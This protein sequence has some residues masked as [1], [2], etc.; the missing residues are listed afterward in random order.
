MNEEVRRVHLANWV[1]RTSQ[2]FTKGVKYQFHQGFLP[3]LRS[4]NPNN[5]E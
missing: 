1:L 3:D 2:E 4:G 5:I